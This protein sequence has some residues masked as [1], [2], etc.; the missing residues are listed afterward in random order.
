MVNCQNSPKIFIKYK[1]DYLAI[2]QETKDAN[3]LNFKD[4]SRQP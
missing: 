2:D 1:L 3:E 4:L